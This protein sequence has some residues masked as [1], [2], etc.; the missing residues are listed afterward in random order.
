MVANIKD[1]AYT[2]SFSF[3][4]D[5]MEEIDGGFVVHGAKLEYK[6]RQYRHTNPSRYHKK[7]RERRYII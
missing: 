2:F 7:K 1:R 5:Q 6:K 3:G 4:P